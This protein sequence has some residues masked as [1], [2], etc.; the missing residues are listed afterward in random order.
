MACSSR[1]QPSLA[2]QQPVHSQ[3]C[4]SR[5]IDA[6]YAAAAAA[7]HAVQQSNTA[8]QLQHTMLQQ[9]LTQYG[10]VKQSQLDP[11]NCSHS[12]LAAMAATRLHSHT[13]AM[14]HLNRTC[15]ASN[16]THSSFSMLVC[17]MLCCELSCKQQPAPIGF[18]QHA[19]MHSVPSTPR[20]AAP[21]K[22]LTT[23]W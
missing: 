11:S 3:C 23:S 14:Q 16:S 12:A 5:I 7:A 9:P 21:R 18:W 15:L 22:H 2:K 17:S 8:Q 19:S 6:I 1:L 13:D 4:I 20:T 10:A